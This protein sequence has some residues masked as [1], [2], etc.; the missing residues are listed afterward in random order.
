MYQALMRNMNYL[1]AI[2]NAKN[3]LKEADKKISD[4]VDNTK[5]AIQKVLTRC[6]S[7]I[8]EF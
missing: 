8:K 3:Q 5:D 6:R 4:L 2:Q 7:M 1:K